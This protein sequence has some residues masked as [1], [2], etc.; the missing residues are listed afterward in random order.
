MEVTMP[1]DAAYTI[2][3]A[4]PH[5]IFDGI[6]VRLGLWLISQPARKSAKRKA[7]LIESLDD[8]ALYDI[9]ITDFTSRDGLTGLARM[10]PCVLAFGGRSP[11]KK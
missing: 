7:Q 8:H 5:S 11:V 1:A 9:G 4:P 10:H 3:F 2:E 6:R